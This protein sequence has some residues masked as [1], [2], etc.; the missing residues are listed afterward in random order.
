MSCLVVCNKFLFPG[1]LSLRSSF[2]FQTYHNAINGT[3]NLFPSNGSLVLTSGCDCG[4]IHKIFELSSTETR[5][6]S[7]NSLKI[8][9]SLK[10]FATCVDTEDLCTALVVR[11]VNSDLTV[12]SSWTKQRIIKNVHTIGGSNG[13]DTWISVETV[14]LNK[15][16]IDSLFTFVVSSCKTSS[17]L[18]S[19][20]INLINEDDAGSVFLRLRED[21]TNARGTDT[22]KHLNEFGT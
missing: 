17:T 15:N 6:S 13:N 3:I 4:L 8:D 11:K 20:G 12:E 22:N 16:L 9:I 21:V 1:Y 18:T 7:C 10:G 14:H 5:S 19:Y 2:L